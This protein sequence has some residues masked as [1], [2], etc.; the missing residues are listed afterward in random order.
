VGRDEMLKD[1]VITPEEW[2][3]AIQKENKREKC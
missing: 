3:V 1:I 2:Y